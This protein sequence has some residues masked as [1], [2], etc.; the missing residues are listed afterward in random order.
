MLVRK[1]LQESLFLF[2]S[3]IADRSD[4]AKKLITDP[5]Q[6]WSQTAGGVEA[7]AK[8]IHKVLDVL[9]ERHRRMALMVFATRPYICLRTTQLFALSR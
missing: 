1:P 6:L 3:V 4:F 8:R 5:A 9:E 7:H 2:E